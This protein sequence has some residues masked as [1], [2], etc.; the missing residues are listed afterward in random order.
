MNL[1]SF[2]KF[3][4]VIVKNK[5]KLPMN[6]THLTFDDEFN[7]SVL[8][9]VPHTVTHL[10]FGKKFDQ[11]IITSGE[12]D[13][14]LIKEL[15]SLMDTAK[16]N[17]AALEL[18]KKEHEYL[19]DPPQYHIPKGVTHVTFGENFRRVVIACFPSSTK[20]IICVGNI[21]GHWKYKITNLVRN[22]CH[23]LFYDSVGEDSVTLILKK[24]KYSISEVIHSPYY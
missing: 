2:D 20:E 15:V 4:N 7:E 24:S 19:G 1:P 10:T 17:P 16:T 6:V 23:E 3:T 8:G 5:V 22:A 11:D 9:Y 12:M 18:F 21:N 14:S 13:D